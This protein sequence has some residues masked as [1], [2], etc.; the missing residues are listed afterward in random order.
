MNSVYLVSL[1]NVLLAG[2][3]QGFVLKSSPEGIL[4]SNDQHCGE[5]EREG[6]LVQNFSY[7]LTDRQ[8]LLF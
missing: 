3:A 6:N 4:W 1:V 8:F 7:F 2:T 5:G